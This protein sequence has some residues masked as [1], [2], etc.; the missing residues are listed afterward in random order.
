MAALT[1]NIEIIEKDPRQLALP[2]VAADIIYRGAMVMHNAAGF[3]APAVAEAGAVF[4]GI[5][6][7]KADNSAGAAGDI[8]VIISNDGIHL[9]N[10]T[11]FA[12]ANV[13]SLVYA[14]DDQ[15]I[16]TTQGSNEQLVGRIEQFVSATQVYVDIKPKA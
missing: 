4:A 6:G 14:S 13:G 8:N 2:V 15:T 1:D 9:L 7:E 3:A 11:G 5:A 12:Q 16:S 10:G